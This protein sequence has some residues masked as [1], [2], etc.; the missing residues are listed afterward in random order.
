MGQ[1]KDKLYEIVQRIYEILV[2]WQF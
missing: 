2:K 1:T